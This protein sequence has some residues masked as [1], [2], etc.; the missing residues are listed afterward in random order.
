MMLFWYLIIHIA[1]I[2]GVGGTNDCEND[3]RPY[4]W[5][6]VTCDGVKR[7]GNCHIPEISGFCCI[8]CPEACRPQCVHRC[9]VDFRPDSRYTCAQQAN[10]EKCGELWMN[11][12]CCISC[13]EACD[14]CQQFKCNTDIAPS[15]A[16]T[17]AQ[18][19]AWG[20]CGEP[21]MTG[22]CCT[23]CPQSCQPPC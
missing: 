4:N 7:A 12:H 15:I 14:H 1:V 2:H 19:A 18:Q 20:K 3:E 16:Y 10:W 5:V 8:S 22:Y 6:W 17:C 21:W 23:S 9:D 13:A 11:G